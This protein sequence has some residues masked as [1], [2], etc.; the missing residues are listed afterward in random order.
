MGLNA[1]SKS[2]VAGLQLRVED[3]SIFLRFE[4]IYIRKSVRYTSLSP[5]YSAPIPKTGPVKSQKPE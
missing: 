4:V 5:V 1:E 2:P 3:M